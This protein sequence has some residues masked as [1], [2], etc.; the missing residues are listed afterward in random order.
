MS[1]SRGKFVIDE[2]M[3][4]FDLIRTSTKAG[5]QKENFNRTKGTQVT[6]KGQNLEMFFEPSRSEVRRLLIGDNAH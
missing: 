5:V 2:Q 6:N 3:D 1:S 4:E